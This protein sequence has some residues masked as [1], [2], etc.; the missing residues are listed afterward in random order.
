MGDLKKKIV[1]NECFLY[2]ESDLTFIIFMGL[3]LKNHKDSSKML[4][5]GGP[6]A[7]ASLLTNKSA[8]DTDV[9][10]IDVLSLFMFTLYERVSR[11]L[12]RKSSRCIT[13]SYS[14]MI[15]G[16]RIILTEL[17]WFCF[18]FIPV[19]IENMLTITVCIQR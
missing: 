2:P 17:D 8:T 6:E 1:L 3:V 16:K 13:F 10:V 18:V 4:E 15:N 5:I 9:L 12:H 7:K 19:R 14:T 11:T